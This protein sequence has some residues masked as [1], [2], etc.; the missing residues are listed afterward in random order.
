MRI[1]YQVDGNTN[2]EKDRAG[3]RLLPM[4]EVMVSEV[5]VVTAGYAPEFG[6]TMGLVYN[7]ITPSGTNQ[8]HGD[9]SYL[10]RRKSFSAFPF[11]FTRPE[12]PEN[13]PD[14]KV[15]TVTGTLGGPI[16]KS[17]LLYYVGYERTSRD[18]SA[19][20]VITIP[21]DTVGGARPDTAAERHSGDAGRQ[22]LHRQGRLSG[23]RGEPLHRPLS[24]VPQRLA[25]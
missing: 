19:Q 22:V 8:T 6:Q 25:L 24:D 10:F 18:L 12:T 14:T 4:S 21:Q 15:D 16:I 9:A 3:L 2:T 11:P 17:K 5:K 23:E 13:K 20:R 7:A 1:N